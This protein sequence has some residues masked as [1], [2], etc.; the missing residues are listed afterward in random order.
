VPKLFRMAQNLEVDEA[1]F[2]GNTINT[3]SMLCV[4]DYIDAL[5]WAQGL[6]GLPGLYARA[7]ANAA[8]VADWIERTPWAENLVQ[9]KTIRSNTALCL[10]FADPAVRRLPRDQQ[11]KLQARIEGLL[12]EEGAAF[13]CGAY[14]TAPP[15]LRIWCGAT[16][17]KAD[18][19]ALLPW[20]EWAYAAALAE[21]APA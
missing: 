3:P 9:D 13:D 21:L 17:A 7:D 11:A 6:G 8:V 1:L 2:D 16:V 5:T 19:E 14:R 10:R 20:L 4:E 15:G 18:L 12:A